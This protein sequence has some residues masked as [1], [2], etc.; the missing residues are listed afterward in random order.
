MEPIHIIAR[1]SAMYSV[2]NQYCLSRC[3]YCYS[4]PQ[5]V[6]TS[7]N[8]KPC[9]SVSKCPVTFQ[10]G[11]ASCQPIYWN[12]YDYNFIQP[13]PVLPPPSSPLSIPSSPFSS[14]PPFPLSENTR[15][16]PIKQQE[17]A[18]AENAA[19]RMTT[20]YRES[21]V[22][23]PSSESYAT[24]HLPTICTSVLVL[25]RIAFNYQTTRTRLGLNVKK[26]RQKQTTHHVPPLPSCSWWPGYMFHL[27]QVESCLATWQ[28]KKG[29]SVS[30]WM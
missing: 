11:P 19:W 18:A 28:L 6:A 29:A 16:D 15:W 2:I 22:R 12:K 20:L 13:Q 21:Q 26:S 5:T 8:Y 7:L 3:P 24:H 30:F 1:Y 27:T 25:L 14:H 10:S 9:M 4:S 23:I 17:G